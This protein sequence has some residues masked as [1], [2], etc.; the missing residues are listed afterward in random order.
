MDAIDNGLTQ[1]AKVGNWVLQHT[2]NQS[3]PDHAVAKRK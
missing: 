1:E 2:L 3:S